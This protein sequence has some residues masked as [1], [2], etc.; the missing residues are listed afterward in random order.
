MRISDWSSDVCS[1]DLACGPGNNGGDGYVLAR[2]AREAGRQVR[3]LR[4]PGHAPRSEIAMRAERAYRDAGG[5]VE[6]FGDSI[7]DADLVV[8]ALFGIGLAR[9]P[10]AETAALGAA[11]H[12][13]RKSAVEGQSRSVRVTLGGCR[14]IPKKTKNK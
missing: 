14:S 13:D 7:G 8:D 10:D 1:S 6:E 3:V 4:L 5:S 9:P 12:E 11:L 2:H